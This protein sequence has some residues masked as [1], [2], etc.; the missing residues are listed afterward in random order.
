MS[1]YIEKEKNVVD[2]NLSNFWGAPQLESCCASSEFW[3]SASAHD[4]EPEELEWRLRFVVHLTK[5]PPIILENQEGLA[6]S[7]RNLQ[8]L[9]EG[10]EGKCPTFGMS[11]F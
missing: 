7:M 6:V 2:S 8:K 10:I 4:R 9:L 1:D 3:T 11:W 5:E